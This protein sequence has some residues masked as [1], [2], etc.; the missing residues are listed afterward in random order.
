M[1]LQSKYIKF[2]S[3]LQMVCLVGA[4]WLPKWDLDVKENGV[5]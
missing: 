4:V 5:N 3:I 1:S 2:I